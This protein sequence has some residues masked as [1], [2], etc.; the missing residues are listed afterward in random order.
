LKVAAFIFTLLLGSVLYNAA[1][2]LPKPGDPQAVL[3]V[4]VSS[5]YLER[6]AVETGLSNATPAVLADY[7][8]FDLLALCFL[9]FLAAA[10][11]LSLLPAGR[12]FHLG[13]VLSLLGVGLG[14][15]LGFFCVKGGSNFLDYEPLAAS[16]NHALAR[17]TGSRLLGFAALFSL[18]G[19]WFAFHQVLKAHEENSHGN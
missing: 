17:A 8:G 14:L 16:V 15:A 4:H 2:L 1:D 18:L 3:S 12:R 11:F 9:F 6:S 7:R 10:V 5:R 13:I 19:A